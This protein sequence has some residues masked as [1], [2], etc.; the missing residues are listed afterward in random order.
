MINAVSGPATTSQQ[1]AATSFRRNRS[2]A[3]EFQKRLADA[4][5]RM[6]DEGSSYAE[7]SVDKLV[8]EAGLARSTFYKYF[9]DKSG[10]LSNLADAVKDDFLRAANPWLE[11]TAGAVKGEYEAA[12]AGIFEAYRSHRVVM[13]CIAEQADQDSVIAGHFSAMMT[14]FIAAIEQHIAAGQRTKAITSVRPAH[15]LAVWLTWM[16]EDGQARFVGPASE[17]ELREYTSAVTD[18]MWKAL[19]SDRASS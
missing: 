11:M 9:G 15:D 5:E 18:V 13:R 1:R 10:L 19:Y 16:L 7:L 2:V 6:M 12:F 14:S 4:I 3:L 17:D 8:G